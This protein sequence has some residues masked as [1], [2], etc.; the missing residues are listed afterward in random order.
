MQP[1]THPKTEKTPK[2]HKIPYNKKSIKDVTQDEGVC[3][4]CALFCHGG[5]KLI[6]VND[7]NPLKT[8]CDC[9]AGWFEDNKHL[10][11]RNP[12]KKLRKEAYCT[13]VGSKEQALD[14]EEIKEKEWEFDQEDY[15]NVQDDLTNISDPTHSDLEMEFDIEMDSD[16]EDK[17]EQRI[18]DLKKK[19]N[20]KEFVADFIRAFELPQIPTECPVKDYFVFDPE[21]EEYIHIIEHFIYLAFGSPRMSFLKIF[22]VDI[23]SNLKQEDLIEENKECCALATLV[24]IAKCDLENFERYGAGLCEALKI[25][26]EKENS[27][28][29]K[30]KKLLLLVKGAP[31]FKSVEKKKTKRDEDGDEENEKTPDEEEEE[32]LIDNDVQMYDEVFETLFGKLSK[33]AK[34]LHALCCISQ[35][36][37][38]SLVDEVTPKHLEHLKVTILHILINIRLKLIH[39]WRNLLALIK[40]QKIGLNSY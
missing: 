3:E 17:E 5:H 13:F 37:L 2:P 28:E 30:V 11:S 24:S 18:K 27:A 9:G 34:V 26:S 6:P 10:N 12:I 4:V 19:Y 22:C 32:E 1:S 14:V 35:E 39:F 21:F 29:D 36:D 31:V 16:Q 15:D 8:I 20:D 25:D 33:K 7:G 38:H 40:K 23:G